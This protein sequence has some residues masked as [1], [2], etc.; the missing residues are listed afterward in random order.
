MTKS[1]CTLTPPID[2]GE[3]TTPIPLGKFTPQPETWEEQLKSAYKADP[4]K[5]KSLANYVYWSF[6]NASADT[7][8]ERC[9]ED[10]RFL[11]ERDPISYEIGVKFINKD[12]Q[13]LFCAQNAEIISFPSNQV[14]VNHGN[15]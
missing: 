8:F 6:A 14:E 13:K 7:L 9:F 12:F 1:N 3:P 15:I 2:Q 5:F 11:K 4:K 10:L